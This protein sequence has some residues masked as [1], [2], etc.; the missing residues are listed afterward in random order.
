MII[1]QKCPICEGTGFVQGGFYNAVPGGLKISV[2][3]TE[4]CRNCSGT[5]VVYVRQY[6]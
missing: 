6:D 2:T 5:G 3:S 1:Q 4:T